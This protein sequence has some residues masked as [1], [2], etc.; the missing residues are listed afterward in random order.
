MIIGL[1]AILLCQLC[2]EAISYETGIPVPGPVIGMLLML[3]LLAVTDRLPQARREAVTGSINGVSGGI[4]ANL[5]L[6]FIPAGVGVIQN[7][8]LLTGHGL[9]LL[10]AVAGSTV[11]TLTVTVLVFGF[12]ARLTGQ[13]VNAATQG[14]DAP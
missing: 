8:G 4:L 3:V 2:G 5:S 14:E 6:L 9:G 12:V 13:A 7:I 10:I 11:A 1:C